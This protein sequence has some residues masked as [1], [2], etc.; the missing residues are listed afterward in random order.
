MPG[1]AIETIIGKA[2]LD[3]EF[4]EALIADPVGSLTPTRLPALN[5]GDLEWLVADHLRVSRRL[6]REASRRRLDLRHVV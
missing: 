6:E 2:V 5:E 1:E 4:R 3:G